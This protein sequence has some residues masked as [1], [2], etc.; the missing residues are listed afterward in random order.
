MP[1][2]RCVLRETPS[3]LGIESGTID[4]VGSGARIGGEQGETLA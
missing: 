3:T 1:Q 2:A 4:G